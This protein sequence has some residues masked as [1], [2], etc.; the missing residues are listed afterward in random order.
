MRIR[1]TIITIMLFSIT[2]CIGQRSDSNITRSVQEAKGLKVGTRAPQ[3]TAIDADSNSFNL[4]KALQKGPIVIIFYRGYWCPVCN[5][6]LSKLQDSLNLIK[7]EGAQLIT[8]SPEQP[9]YLDKM[10]EKTGAQFTLLYDQAYRISKAFDVVYKPKTGELITYNL[11]LGAKLKNTHS[12]E[13]QQLPIP[14]TFII[15][16]NGIIVWRQFDP[17]YHNRSNVKE[18]IYQLQKLESE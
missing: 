10:R 14:A 4:T 5:K 17:N 3:F 9:E 2:A 6:H 7:E 12:D 11:I 13:S 15:D 1:I 8:I 18:I 16:T